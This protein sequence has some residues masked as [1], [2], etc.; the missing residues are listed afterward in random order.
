MIQHWQR[1]RQSQLW[2]RLRRWWR[3][4]RIRLPDPGLRSEDLQ[5]GD[6]LQI[7]SELWRVES[8]SNASPAATSP[9]VIFLRTCEAT[10]GAQAQAEL[11]VGSEGWRLAL[12]HGAPPIEVD[13]AALIRY[14][15]SE[16]RVA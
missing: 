4:P 8:R 6:R 14:P 16:T 3:E 5:T 11:R 1:F 7:G 15:V 13:P 12:E 9:C 10:G 2:L